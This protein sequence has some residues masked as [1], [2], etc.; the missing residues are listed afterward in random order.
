M[1]TEAV[2][3]I[4]MWVA[5]FLTVLP[6]L[7]ALQPVLD[8]VGVAARALIISGL[9]VPLMRHVSLPAAQALRRGAVR[10]AMR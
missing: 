2:E 9:M 1:K 7:F 6:I 3:L 4:T 5:A 8:E 10:R